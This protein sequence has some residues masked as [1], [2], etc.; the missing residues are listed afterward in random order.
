MRSKGLTQSR[1]V[2]HIR[3]ASIAHVHFQD[4][5]LPALLHDF[6]QGLRHDCSWNN[7]HTISWQ[8]ENGRKPQSQLETD[9][10]CWINHIHW[11]IQYPTQEK[12]KSSHKRPD[13]RSSSEASGRSLWDT[14]SWIRWAFGQIQQDYYVQ[15][16]RNH[17]ITALVQKKL[18]RWLFSF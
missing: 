7:T 11:W 1:Y 17:K 15:C 14:R 16:N 18:T 12:K 3:N 5:L 9:I 8:K 13:M 2:Q 6:L 10:L 4:V